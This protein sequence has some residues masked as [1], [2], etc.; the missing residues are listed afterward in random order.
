MACAMSF[1]VDKIGDM[2]M[3]TLIKDMLM[4]ASEQ[5][6]PGFISFQLIKYGTATKAPK[7]VEGCLNLITAM[8]DEYGMNGFPLKE[9]IDF[10]KFATTNANPGVRTASMNLFCELYKFVGEQVRNFLDGV[11]DSTLKMINDA[12]GKVS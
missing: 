9:I 5:V 4:N 1:F 12:L 3:S 2:K 8:I 11:K 6:T 10:A 7:N